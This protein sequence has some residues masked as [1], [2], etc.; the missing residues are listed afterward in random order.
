MPAIETFGVIGCGEFGR[1]A[2]THLAPPESEVQIFD[3]NP[4]V[5]IPSAA[6]RV[7]FEAVSRADVIMLAVP[8]DSYDIVLPRLTD[9]VRPNSL[10]VDVCS[11]KI[12]PEET[13]ASYQ[14]LERE[15]TLMTHPLFGSQSI[16]DNSVDKHIVI[17]QQSGNLTTE[18]LDIW[19]SRGIT[20]TV[21]TAEQHDREM[22]KVHAL[23]FF[24]GRALLEMGVESSATNTPYFNELL[25]LI[26][27]E[28]HHSLELFNTIQRHN[29]FA[30]DMRQEFMNKLHGLDDRI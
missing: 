12:L 23:T 5:D 27:V 3:S 19:Q 8:F 25:D 4:E 26:E 15:N 9:C 30:A 1:I 10:I 24:I 20:T 16:D 14:L 7:G 2:A 13:F 11:V 21:M 29:P 22:A 28:K 18:L 17:T 6:R